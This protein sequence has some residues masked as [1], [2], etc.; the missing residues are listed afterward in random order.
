MFGFGKK[1]KKAEEKKKSS[2]EKM[3]DEKDKK[4]DEEKSNTSEPSE[5][6]PPEK[7][8]RKWFS[9]K[10]I[11]I[12]ILVLI[13]IGAS[14]FV[15]YTF[16]FAPK[17]PTDL[18]TKYQRIEL[19]HIN[20]PEEMLEF[21][22]DYFPDLYATMVTLNNEIELL[23]KEITRIEEIAQKYP[24]QKKIADKETKGLQKARKALQKVFL[25]IEKPVK[26]IYVLFQVNKELGQ[27][28]I[29]DKNKELTELAQTALTPAQELTQKFKSTEEIPKGFIK[30]T[31]YKLKKK[32]L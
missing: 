26:E 6:N 21:S 17:D 11:F 5:E 31:I 19:V 9:K 10:L 14:V 2:E 18:I 4:E 25:K 24:D 7:K 3:P 20:L 12:I 28:Q 16:Y 22:F 29:E 8:K 23:N 15:V 30:G 1:K 32:F 13:A 27:I